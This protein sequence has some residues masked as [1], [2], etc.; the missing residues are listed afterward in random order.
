MVHRPHYV[1]ADGR[2]RCATCGRPIRSGSAEFRDGE[3]QSHHVECETANRARS[4]KQAGVPK[5]EMK[6]R[7]SSNEDRRSED[8]RTVTALA[9][10]AGVSRPTME[11]AT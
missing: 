1:E 4:E 7:G 11:R 8:N 9:K 10:E 6:E 3:G 5:A 2:Q